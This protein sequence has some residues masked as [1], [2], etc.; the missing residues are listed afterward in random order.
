MKWCCRTERWLSSTRGWEDDV[1]PVALNIETRL[2]DITGADYMFV[3]HAYG[4]HCAATQIINER[5]AELEKLGSDTRLIDIER[6][7]WYTLGA[8]IEEE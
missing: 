4:D 2:E 7:K 6:G 8:F 3:S 5:F 1:I